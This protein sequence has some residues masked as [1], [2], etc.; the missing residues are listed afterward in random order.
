MNDCYYAKKDWRECK[1]EV[2]YNIRQTE[3][4]SF[5]RKPLEGQ[6]C[7]D[8]H[9]TSSN[10]NELM[11]QHIA[12]ITQ[13]ILTLINTDGSFPRVLEAPGQR[14]ANTNQRRIMYSTHP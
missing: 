2:S 1:K 14:S 9:Y 5:H 11:K 12:P 3:H 4:I 10:T 7:S 6:F 13:I 8:R